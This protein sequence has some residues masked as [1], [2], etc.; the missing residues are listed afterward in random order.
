MSRWRRARVSADNTHHELDGAPLYAERFDE[1]LSFHEPG[2]AAVRRGPDAWHIND[3][4]GKALEAAHDRRGHEVLE[5]LLTAQQEQLAMLMQA[6]ADQRHDYRGDLERLVHGYGEH[7][8]R[9]V[10]KL[11]DE[12][13]PESISQIG[14]LFHLSAGKITGALV[15][16]E[17][18]HGKS[19][20]KQNQVL[21]V[22]GNLTKQATNLLAVVTELKELGGAALTPQRP[23][24][25]REPERHLAVVSAAPD[26][27]AVI[28]D[29]L[30]EEDDL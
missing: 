21:E 8:E 19:I 10:K 25:A 28:R 15:R 2:L 20:E 18:L 11:S 14:E 27:L 29:D 22:L 3:L 13:T 30:D 26:V 1:A 12:L 23:A 4:G 7:L 17:H 6:L 5:T 24:P 9:A 16:A